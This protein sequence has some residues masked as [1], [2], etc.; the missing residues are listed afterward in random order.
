M[1]RRGRRVGICVGGEGIGH[2]NPQTYSMCYTNI[3]GFCE[4]LQNSS[5]SREEGKEV[6]EE[7]K[8][9]FTQYFAPAE[10]VCPWRVIPGT[11]GLFLACSPLR[12]EVLYVGV[13]QG[14]CGG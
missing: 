9:I 13:L 5:N 1:G 2:G 6:G 4:T 12:E 8:P 3:K 10:T 14:V 11:L 7:H